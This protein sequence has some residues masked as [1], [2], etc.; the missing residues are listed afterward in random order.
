MPK[1]Q[2]LP[3]TP[4][5]KTEMS[6]NSAEQTTPIRPFV[7]PQSPDIMKRFFQNNQMD[8]IANDELLQEQIQ[9]DIGYSPRETVNVNHFKD[10][11]QTTPSKKSE[12]EHEH[13]HEHETTT[14][15]SSQLFVPPKEE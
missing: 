8:D 2:I 9:M 10:I 15:T 5:N 11:N 14:F 13:E 12:H 6:A 7:G 3:F 4:P 1:G